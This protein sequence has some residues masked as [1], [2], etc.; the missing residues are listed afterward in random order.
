MSFNFSNFTKDLKSFGDKISTEFNKEV[1]PLAQRTSRLVQEKMGN[2]KQDDISQLP[3]EYI[4]LANKCNNIEQLYKNVLKIT[5]NYENES[6]DYPTN[7]QESFTEFGKNIT[8]RVSNVAKATTT[9]EAQAAL[10]NPNTG[11]FKAP[12]TL[13][14]ALSRATDASILTSD[15]SQDPLIKGLDLYSSNLNKIA[16]ARLG[17]DQLIKSKF[18]KPLLT[19][20]RSLISQSN[21][22]QKKVEDKRIDYDL[23]RSNLASCTNPQKEPKLRVDMENAE[24]EFANTVE[25]AINIMQNVLENAKPLEEFLELI[26]AQLA[27]HKLAT[28]L[29][30]GMVKDFEELIDE[31]HK[32]SGSATSGRESGDFDI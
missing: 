13:Y 3:S 25:D 7:V 31:Q 23:T 16:N 15:K 10:I 5:T 8:T 17:Q 6:Y 11:E 19:T 27:Y 1:V 21:N 24:D 30:D 12:K 26:K 28:E 22:I 9:A 32:L 20:L 18:N 2:I 4:E 14:H 29:L